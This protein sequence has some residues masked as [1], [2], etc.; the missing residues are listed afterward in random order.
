MKARSHS[1]LMAKRAGQK[2][3]ASDVPCKHCGGSVRYV[4]SCFCV[5]CAITRRAAAR[6]AKVSA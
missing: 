3:Y 4:S 1:W 5:D 6:A 2:K